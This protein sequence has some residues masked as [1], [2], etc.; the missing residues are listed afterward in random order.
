MQQS[1]R[2]KHASRQPGTSSSHSQSRRFLSYP[3]AVERAG[4]SSGSLSRQRSPTCSRS[5]RC[6]S[7]I[8]YPDCDHGAR[9]AA[10]SLS[11]WICAGEYQR[12]Q[13][14]RCMHASLCLQSSLTLHQP[15]TIMRTCLGELD[16]C[17]E[18][19]TTP[20]FLN[21]LS[22]RYGWVPTMD[23][24]PASVAEQYAWVPDVSI[25]HMEI[26]HGTAV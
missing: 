18:D 21:I 8:P 7:R 9:G 11:R 25:T 16:R 24:V 2:L 13:Q 26:L 23:E 6:S 4:R 17:Y 3:S 20:F 15:Q 10:S 1:N 22:H 19:N 12:N 14:Q 5:A